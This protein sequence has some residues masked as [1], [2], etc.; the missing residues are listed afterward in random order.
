MTELVMFIVATIS[1]V[2]VALV[3]Y[4]RTAARWRSLGFERGAV[5][6]AFASQGPAFAPRPVPVTGDMGFA[7]QLK[8]AF[9]RT[10]P[11]FSRGPTD[12]SPSRASSG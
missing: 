6:A 10:S 4:R 9:F 2:V 1:V 11:A 12:R 3:I 7:A 5:P 8:T